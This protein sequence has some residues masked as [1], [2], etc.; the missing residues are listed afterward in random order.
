MSRR[1]KSKEKFG[2]SAKKSR[3]VELRRLPICSRVMIIYLFIQSDG[4]SSLL[5]KLAQRVQ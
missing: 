4:G 5:V 2:Q 1:I 3:I